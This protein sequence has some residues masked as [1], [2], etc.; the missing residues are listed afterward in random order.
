MS[1]HRSIKMH[2]LFMLLIILRG[3]RTPFAPTTFTICVQLCLS[4]VSI[5]TI[6]GLAA[7]GMVPSQEVTPTSQA[8]PAELTTSTPTIDWFPATFTP[9]VLPT[10]PP[11]TPTPVGTPS[12]GS[13][14]YQDDFTRPGLWTTG[15]FAA[16]GIAYGKG[17]LSLAVSEPRGAL[18]STR[19]EPAL[20]NFY[21]EVTAAPS[22]CLDGDNY[23]VQ[24]RMSSLKDFYRFILSC[25]GQV[26]LERIK[27]GTGLVLHDWTASAQALPN[28]SGTYRLGIRAVG[29]DLSLYINDVL[30]F[31]AS[32]ASL[33]SGGLGLLVRSMG[34]T[35]VTVNFTNLA[36]YK[37][38]D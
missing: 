36:V 25:V 28:A 20:S 18:T 27:D 4:V 16:G 13:L 5:S 21:L 7:C 31:S 38:G 17:E 23:G 24:F 1:E 2:I 22:L 35:A 14:I 30:Q 32:D 33:S 10:A 19:L 11:T 3:G 26:R 29:S 12:R 37:P 8:S 6:V 34:S 9:T 15:Q